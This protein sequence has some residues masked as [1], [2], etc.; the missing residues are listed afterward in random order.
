MD[1]KALS[2]LLL[3]GCITLL[4][5]CKNQV[6]IRKPNILF[7]AVDDL[8]PE[9]NCYG[10]SEIVLPNIDKPASEGILW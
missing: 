1:K 8:R 3:L 2:K 9:L 6:E 5:S 4:F 10:K 7:I